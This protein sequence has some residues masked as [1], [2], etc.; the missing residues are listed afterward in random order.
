MLTVSFLPLRLS[1]CSITG[2]GYA[3]LASALKSKASHLVE[4]DLG[5]N[6]PG[7]S[8]VEQL[9]G[10][11]NSLEDSNFKQ[12]TLRW[13]ILI[14]LKC[15][16]AGVN[17]SVQNEK[18][19]NIFPPSLQVADYICRQKNLTDRAGSEWKETRRLWSEAVIS[20]T[21]GFTLQIEDTYVSALYL[22]VFLCH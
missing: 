19:V 15:V 12:R 13:E 4:L 10:L 16:F 7:D 22:Y 20:S 3:T 18:I 21:E 11:C 6:D 5:G 17:I 2:E 1:D 9:T 8:G 14:H